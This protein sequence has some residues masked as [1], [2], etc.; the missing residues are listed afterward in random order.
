[1]QM[2]HAIRLLAKKFPYAARLERW[3][4]LFPSHSI[5]RDPRAKILVRWRCHESNVQRAV[6][7]AAQRCHLDGLAKRSF[8]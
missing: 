3:A 4:W 5:C 7:A 6:R 1:M 2:D 8:L